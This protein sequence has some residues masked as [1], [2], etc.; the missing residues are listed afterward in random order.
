MNS[1]SS[2]CDSICGDGRKYLTEECDDGG[3]ED[4]DGCD[5]S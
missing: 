4:G 5:A 1:D 3:I 2:D